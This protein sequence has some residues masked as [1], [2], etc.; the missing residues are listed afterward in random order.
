MIERKTIREKYNSPLLNS[1]SLFL[2]LSL[3]LCLSLSLSLSLSFSFS[4]YLS[5][6]F[7]LCLS[8]SLSVSLSLSLS[9]SHESH[10]KIKILTP[11]LERFTLPL[12]RIRSL[13]LLVPTQSTFSLPSDL[14]LLK[15]KL[16]LPGPMEAEAG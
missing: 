8:V 3:S 1:L 14:K 6:S 16:P 10:V 11:Y 4:L 15:I 5:F 9:L 2:S 13:S 12:N 7:S